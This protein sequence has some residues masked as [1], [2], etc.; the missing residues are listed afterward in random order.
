MSGES[1]LER[2]LISYRRAQFSPCILLSV[3]VHHP[4][5]AGNSPSCAADLQ[6]GAE[7]CKGGKAIPRTD[8]EESH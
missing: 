6:E 1:T 7:S 4:K 5:G 2:L 3:L 8:G